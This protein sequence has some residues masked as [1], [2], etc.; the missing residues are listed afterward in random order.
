[1]EVRPPVDTGRRGEPRVLAC[2][3]ERLA[4]EGKQ[5]TWLP[6]ADSIGEDGVLRIAGHLGDFPVQIVT[7]TPGDKVFWSAV[8]KG[9]GLASGALTEAADWIHSAI[10]KKADRY[11]KEVRRRMLLAL[12]L[13]HMG[14]L[15][16]VAFGK[17]YLMRHGDPSAL[18]DFGAVWLVGPTA[19]RILRLGTSRW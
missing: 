4:I 13:V 1:L 12:D 6:A 15:C 9:N 8:A 14:V 19:D 3:A 17:Q 18:F 2:I 5:S 7:P 11:A 10:G 16:D